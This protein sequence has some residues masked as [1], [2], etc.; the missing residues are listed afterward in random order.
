MLDTDTHRCTVY[1]DRPTTCRA[2]HAC[3]PPPPDTIDES[4]PTCPTCPAAVPGEGCFASDT[5]VAHGHHTVVWQISADVQEYGMGKLLKAL[6]RGGVHQVKV[7]ILP[8]LVLEHGQR[9]YGW[10]RKPKAPSLQPMASAYPVGDP[11]R[12]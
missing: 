10:P 7:G 5:D 6:G 12:A 8:L 1:A 2:H 3:Q 9:E 11:R 4:P